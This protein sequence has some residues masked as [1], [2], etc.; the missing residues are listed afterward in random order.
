MMV[1]KTQFAENGGKNAGEI[2]HNR[3]ERRPLRGLDLHHK[4]PSG[5]RAE[6]HREK[7]K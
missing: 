7:C 1:D 2:L 6:N 4:E 5:G 3:G